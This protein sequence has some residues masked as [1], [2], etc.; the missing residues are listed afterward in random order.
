VAGHGICPWWVGYLPASPLRRLVVDPGHLL[1]PF[2]HAGMTVLEPGPGLGFFTL[3]MARLVGPAG[4]VIAVDVEPQMIKGL[5]RRARRAGLHDRIDAR[6]VQPTSM[7]LGEAE[8][9]VDFVFACAVV[10]EMPAPTPFFAETA[11]AM[12]PGAA[13]LL[14]E[15][16]GRVNGEK[17][18]GELAAAAQ[19]GLVAISHQPL[20]GSRAALLCKP[21]SWV[22]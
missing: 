3:E 17:F 16:A 10:H 7:T 9:T 18:V 12:K 6:L 14:A 2:V 5:Q 15:P 19:A 8:G 11:R 1:A 20:R 22:G 4:R 21:T 13:F